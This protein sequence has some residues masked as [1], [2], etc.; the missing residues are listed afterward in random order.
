[1]FRGSLTV[2][3]G[4]QYFGSIFF[5]QFELNLDQLDQQLQRI[6]SAP[7]SWYENGSSNYPVGSSN[8]KQDP[9]S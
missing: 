3:R 9:K 1:V 2:R 6:T 4:L 8:L 7:S 5:A